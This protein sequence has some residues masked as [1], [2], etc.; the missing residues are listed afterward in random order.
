MKR[1]AAIVL[2]GVALLLVV[3]LRGLLDPS[4]DRL[5]GIDSGNLYTWE[6][7]TREVLADGALPFWNPY[8]FAG[9]PHLA[10][11]QTTVLY[12]PAMLLRWL[13]APAFLGWM[14]ALHLWIAA[15]GTLF[16]ARVIGLGWLAGTAAAVAVMLG[17]SVPG[18]IH[19]GHLLVLYSAAWT[20][21]A[22]ALAIVFVRSGRLFPDGRL[23]AVL[24][25]QF[26][27]GYLQGSLYLASALGLYFVFAAIRAPAGI[28]AGER[29]SA[30][31][32]AAAR[33]KPLMQL[34]LLAVLCAAATAFQ[35]LPT[36]TLVSQ[37]GR[38][39]GLPYAEALEGGWRISDLAT[40]FFPFH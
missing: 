19:N 31:D 30:N 13:P 10:D 5:P 23:V 33:W 20:P 25:L 18:W 9:T 14:L 1:P 37:A 17:G 34:V 4:T 27:T 3:L 35:L 12:P 22:F 39:A 28:P 11:P 32:R 26:L 36:A 40:L 6:I 21:V 24:M 29:G 38:S 8:H 15:A 2:A 7:Y 16:A